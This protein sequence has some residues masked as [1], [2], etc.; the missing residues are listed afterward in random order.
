MSVA[1]FDKRVDPPRIAGI[2]EPVFFVVPMG[3]ILFVVGFLFPLL[4]IKIAAFSASLG[5]AY[6]SWY[7]WHV[8][9]DFLILSALDTGKK[10]KSTVSLFSSGKKSYMDIYHWRTFCSESAYEHDDGAVSLAFTW[11]GVHDR[12]F[13]DTQFGTEHKRRT[14][15]LKTLP[16]NVGLVIENHLL[17]TN[18]TRLI[19]AYLAKS[20]K[21]A[22]RRETPRIALDIR[23]QLAELYRPM[24]RSN[25][26]LTVLSVGRQRNQG[27]L[28][29]L[30]PTSLTRFRNTVEL[31]KTL[32]EL[33]RSVEASYPGFK[34]LTRD[35]YAHQI[36]DVYRPYGDKH[37][38]DWRFPLAPQ[39]VTEKPELDEEGFLHIDGLYYKCCLIQNYP[40]LKYGWP[41]QFVE[42]AVDLHACQIINPLPTDK[43]IDKENK[44]SKF[45]R[46]SISQTRG[47]ENATNR[48]K[49]SAAYRM[50]V[51]THKLSVANNAYILTFVHKDKGRVSH[52][53]NAFK[54]AIIENHGLVRDNA[55]LQNELFRLRLPGQGRYSSFMREDHADTLAVMA[56][57]TTFPHGVDDP[58]SIRIS[59]TGQIVGSSPSALSV[60]HKLVVAETDGGKDTQEGATFVETFQDIRYDCVELGNSWQGIIEAV[61][62]HYCRAKEQVI[63]PLSNYADYQSARAL[64]ES[65][66]GKIDVDFVRTQSDL[67][68]PIFK[69][70]KGGDFTR[71]EEVVV[72]RL[73]RHIYE[74]PNEHA[75]APILPDLMAAFEQIETESDKQRKARDELGEELFEFLST[76][77]GSAFK[78]RDQFTISPIANGVD[79]DKFSGELF[80]FYMLFI[81]IRFATAAMS[82]GI[83]S[84]IVLNEYKVLLERSPELIRR[85]TLTIDRMGRKDWVGLTRITQ[86]IAEIQS[87]DPEALNSIPNKVL[88][89]RQ[90]DKHET[91]GTMLNMPQAAI[92]HWRDFKPPEVMNKL[93][94]REGMLYEGGQWHRLQYR[95]PPL[96]LDLMNTKGSDR[97]LRDKTYLMSKDPYERIRIFNELRKERDNAII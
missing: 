74:H 62:G 6:L 23:E 2:P 12:F 1:V 22:E 70:M 83:R 68:T 73:V 37:A 90:D 41:F 53:A 3:I 97:V 79:F 32:N 11:D 89:S 63:N 44:K 31:L 7:I 46:E 81:T 77:I 18:D 92:F 84:Q 65:G 69:G 13:D 30:L 76:E 58:E 51:S 9:D 15:L 75:D 80:D 4:V 14:A 43:T 5:C 88:L 67:L 50:Y 17:R 66:A 42:A 20:R 82:R 36:M 16:T 29:A 61:G 60:P 95:F 93:G 25:R 86:G 56:P 55:D 34:L 47:T 52:Y 87:I 49:D 96:L 24:S 85:I 78:D 91:I 94:Y 59:S 64:T 33:V 28:S 45:E 72:N 8:Y 38:I 57:F 35:E 54:K 10:T 39:L 19:D 21:K 27:F 40:E 71:P 26:V 48:L